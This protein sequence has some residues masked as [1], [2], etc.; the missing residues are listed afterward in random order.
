MK[1]NN[2]KAVIY[3]RVASG[4]QQDDPIGSLA[5]QEQLC[6]SYL[7][8]KGYEIHKIISEQASGVR[9]DRSGYKQLTKCIKSGKIQAVCAQSIDRL[10]RSSRDYSAINVLLKK[11]GVELIT[12]KDPATELL[13]TML[14]SYATYQQK[15]ISL[16]VRTALAR[17]KSLLRSRASSKI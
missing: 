14:A 11:H 16:R 15:M 7:R 12:A 5:V 1:Q 4:S 3:C 6:K 17:K 9:S 8:A 13:E 10:T 2:K